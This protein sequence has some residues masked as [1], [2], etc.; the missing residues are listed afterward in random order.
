MREA[1][2]TNSA[3]SFSEPPKEFYGAKAVDARDCVEDTVDTLGTSRA[4]RDPASGLRPSPLLSPMVCESKMFTSRAETQRLHADTIVESFQDAFIFCP[5]RGPPAR[6][7]QSDAG[8][9]PAGNCSPVFHVALTQVPLEAV[10]LVTVQAVTYFKF[11]IIQFSRLF[12]FYIRSRIQ[13]LIIPFSIPSP[14][15]PRVPTAR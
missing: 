13:L 8:D 14:R 7:R 12:L 6:P 11:N 3:R 10:E 4:E 1:R 15:S 5:L 9:A 2:A